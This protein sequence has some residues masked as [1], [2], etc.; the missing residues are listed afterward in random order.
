MK[1]YKAE[2]I[3]K[4]YGDKLLF[5]NIQFSITTGDK[6]GLIGINGTGKSTLLKCMA[7]KDQFDKETISKP[8]DY[9]IR[10]LSQDIELNEADTVLD[11]VFNSSAPIMKTLKNYEQLLL[12]IEKYPENS[13]LQQRLIAMQ[14]DM[15]RQDAWDASA[16]AK[17][18]LNKLGITNYYQ[19]IRELSGGQRKR[20]ALAQVLIETPDL[21]LLDEPTNHLD[22]ATIVWLEKFLKSYPK[23]LLVITHDRYFLDNISTRVFELSKAK[24]YE[25]QGNY[26]E[27]IE[28]KAEREM[29]EATQHI[30]NKQLYKQELAWMRKGA[31]ARTTKQQARINRFNTLENQL[32]Q[33][34]NDE[35][36][37]IQLN[38][39]R[40]GKQVFEL[41]QATKQFEGKEILKDFNFIVQKFA[42]IGIIGENGVGKSTL[43]N[44]LV[45]N[46]LL[47]SGQLI[48][49]QTVKIAYYDQLSQNMDLSMR[50]INYVREG[51]EAIETSSGKIISAAQLLE[52]FLFPLSS[53]GT[54]LYKLSGGERR[55]L[56]LLR[57]LMSKPNVLLLDEP[58]NDLD[59]E[60]LTI[61]EQYLEQFEG[62]VITV[63][64]DRYFLDKIVDDLL[65][66]K[67]N[68]Q[69]EH[70]IGNYSEYV[71]K[72]QTML[73]RKKEN[74]VT[75]HNKQ[76]K[77]KE[78]KRLSYNEKQEWSTIDEEIQQL[79]NQLVQIEQEMLLALEDY[80]LLQ[81][82]TN[83]QQ[84][85]QNDL[86]EKM[87]RWEYLAELVEQ[88]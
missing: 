62:A 77:H 39:S 48:T 27:F 81:Q 66:F 36:M 3:S 61:L 83:E 64:H 58:T 80:Q 87:L 73:N 41:K 34:Q 21:L 70:F 26:S 72:Q 30:K 10:Y 28:K 20:V 44:I 42:R 67:G 14:D 59:T 78:K 18:I 17:I 24:L 53:H 57:L 45:G 22:F 12:D 75:T 15:D 85:L 79:E 55:R 38:S 88:T 33:H 56:Y 65:I 16:N 9:S 8:N 23:S 60:T 51:A 19:P 35:K 71:E 63:S 6:I 43:L 37:N 50:M 52:Q 47:D 2:N 54:P 29:N 7:N 13:Q 4:T 46:S 32:A 82:L 76:M 74:V 1:V 40:L 11:C 31:K 69:I 86:E 84:K 49:G 68:A 5:D 25:Y